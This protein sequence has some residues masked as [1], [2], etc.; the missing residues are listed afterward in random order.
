MLCA[1]P[2]AVDPHTQADDRT[3]YKAA[4]LLRRAEEAGDGAERASLAAQGL[5]LMGR[6]PGAV[7][8]GVVVPQ[9]ALLGAWDGVV[10]LPLQV[11]AGSR[12]LYARHPSCQNLSLFR[13]CACRPASVESA[14]LG[15]QAAVSNACSWSR[16]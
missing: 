7:D 6:V 15:E 14:G 9:L 10:S 3:F 1:T 5:A 16:G 11:R 4:G 13:R 2:L 8:L 12:R